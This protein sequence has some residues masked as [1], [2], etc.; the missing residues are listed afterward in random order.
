MAAREEAGGRLAV[1]RA[2]EMALCEDHEYALER[3][4]GQVRTLFP[5]QRDLWNAIFP[6]APRVS[7]TDDLDTDP[8]ADPT[9]D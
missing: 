9:M 3:V 5:R 2:Q 7:R 4:M 6:P 1:F 8:E